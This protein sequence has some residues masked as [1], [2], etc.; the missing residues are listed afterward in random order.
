M[1]KLR[2][3]FR[4]SVNAPKNVTAC[5]DLLGQVYCCWCFSLLNLSHGKVYMNCGSS[6]DHRTRDDL[7]SECSWL[8]RCEALLATPR[9]LLARSWYHPQ[10]RTRLILRM[11]CAYAIFCGKWR[12]AQSLNTPQNAVFTLPVAVGQYVVLINSNPV[13]IGMRSGQV[14]P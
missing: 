13:E 8:A 11:R 7:G 1:T 12:I 14:S 4:N 6:R 2:V 9:G 10:A 3:A 5:V